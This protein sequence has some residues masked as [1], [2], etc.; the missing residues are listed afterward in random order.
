[1]PYQF[2][3]A[4]ILNS[5]IF[6]SIIEHHFKYIFVFEGLTYVLAF[7]QYIPEKGES[8]SYINNQSKVKSVAIENHLT[9]DLIDGPFPQNFHSN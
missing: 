4:P 9:T 7:P 5:S 3:M 2:Q 6:Q 1:M 8:I